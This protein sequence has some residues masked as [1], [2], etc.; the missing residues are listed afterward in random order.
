[1][2]VGETVAPRKEHRICAGVD[3]LRAIQHI[4]SA[5]CYE[6]NETAMVL[7]RYSSMFSTT[8]IKCDENT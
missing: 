2:Y 7:L 8:L 4:F 3:V 6:T 5:H 1:M